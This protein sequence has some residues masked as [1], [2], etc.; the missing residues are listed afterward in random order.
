VNSQNSN[1]TGQYWLVF[2]VPDKGP[3]EYFDPLGKIPSYY[4]KSFEKFL[5]NN[6]TGY[7]FSSKPVQSSKSSACGYFCLFFAALRCD[8]YSFEEIM[9]FFN[10]ENLDKNTELCISFVKYNY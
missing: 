7:L 9:S 6:S 5:F 1:Q 4:Q 2:Y 3:I 8:G 10:L